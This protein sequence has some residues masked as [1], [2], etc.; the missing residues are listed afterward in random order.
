MCPYLL[1]IPAGAESLPL[2]S[3]SLATFLSEARGASLDNAN[4]LWMGLSQ[5]SSKRKAAGLMRSEQKRKVPYIFLSNFFSPSDKLL[6]L[7]RDTIPKCISS[8]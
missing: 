3:Y 1:F 4:E 7:P 6:F 8:L 5:G 2:L